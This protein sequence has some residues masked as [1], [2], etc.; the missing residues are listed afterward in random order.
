M[1]FFVNPAIA[2]AVLLSVTGLSSVAHAALP[3]Q[4]PTCSA[5]TISGA[6]EGRGSGMSS[7]EAKG[8]VEPETHTV[9]QVFDGK[10]SYSIT[11][12]LKQAG[13]ENSTVLVRV[14]PR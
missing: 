7:L 13:V 14:P 10:G 3:P 1:S 9:R 5:A 11:Q 12:Y 4:Q 6:Y 2:A 8:K